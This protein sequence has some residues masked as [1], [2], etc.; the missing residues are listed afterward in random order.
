MPCIYSPVG[1]RFELVRYF[2]RMWN[3]DLVMYRVC[4][5]NIGY[6]L[7]YIDTDMLRPYSESRPDGLVAE[8]I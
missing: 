3:L 6:T 4:G 2:G 8:E 1:V 7:P 5:L